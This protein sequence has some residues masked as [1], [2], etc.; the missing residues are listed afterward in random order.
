[1]AIRHVEPYT[2]EWLRQPVGYVRR[3]V[4]ALAAEVT[5]WW[6]GPCDPRDVTVRL[7]DG[8]ALVWDEE[9][10]WRLGGFVSGE[11]GEHAQLSEVRYLGGG[12]LPRPERVPAALHD[13][14]AGV[15]ASS[16]WRPCYRSHRNCRDGFD[17]ALDFYVRFVDA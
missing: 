10:G 3:V 7:A 1:M 9:S 15:G 4:D 17:V 16:A 14:R 8:T 12:L 11:R 6:E 13:A 2:D 5:D